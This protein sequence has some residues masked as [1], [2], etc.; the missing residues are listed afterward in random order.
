MQARR[1]FERTHTERLRRELV[2]SSDPDGA[3]SSPDGEN[4]AQHHA[5]ARHRPEPPRRERRARC[6]RRRRRQMRRLQKPGGGTHGRELDERAPPATTRAPP[7]ACERA[8]RSPTRPVCS[9]RR[10][11]TRTHCRRYRQRESAASRTS[12]DMRKR[13]GRRGRAAAG[14]ETRARAGREAEERDGNAWGVETQALGGF[15]GCVS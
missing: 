15:V 11:G 2:E 1:D 10:D 3:S 7:R 12:L 8:R 14:K 5:Q 9:R 13:K 4:L 6:P